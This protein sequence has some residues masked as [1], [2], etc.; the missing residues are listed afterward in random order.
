M[1]WLKLLGVLLALQT[2]YGSS[3]HPI[4]IESELFIGNKESALNPFVYSYVYRG[5]SNHSVVTSRSDGVFFVVSIVNLEIEYTLNLD[6]STYS[7]GY[8]YFDSKGGYFYL[9]LNDKNDVV[10]NQYRP[11]SAGLQFI[12]NIKIYDSNINFN[13]NSIYVDNIRDIVTLVLAKSV[14]QFESKEMVIVNHIQLD[15]TSCRSAETA[16]FNDVYLYI[17]CLGLNSPSFIKLSLYPLT[18]EADVPMTIGLYPRCMV[19]MIDADGILA[20]VVPFDLDKDPVVMVLLHSGNLSTAATY[21]LPF[22]SQHPSI[23]IGNLEHNAFYTFGNIIYHVCVKDQ[24]INIDLDN[25]ATINGFATSGYFDIK[26]Q[27]A[28]FVSSD[29]SL[30]K[31]QIPGVKPASVHPKRHGVNEPWTWWKVTLMVLGLMVG[32]SLIVVLVKVIESVK[33]RRTHAVEDNNHNYHNYI[34]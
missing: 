18:V 29:G 20:A 17:G 24:V 19:N 3:H 1:L 14:I 11:V 5:N 34:L 13:D 12:R 30:Y 31:L 2:V 22:R 32:T 10:V 4:T 25:N 27:R 16:T 26:S 23:A 7:K 15:K 9:C 21:Q 8:G 33:F 28:L 6:P